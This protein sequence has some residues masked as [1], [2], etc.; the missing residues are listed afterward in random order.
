[1]PERRDG[2]FPWLKPA[3]NGTKKPPEVETTGGWEGFLSEKKKMNY[4]PLSE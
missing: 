2:L 3:K 1:M 4:N